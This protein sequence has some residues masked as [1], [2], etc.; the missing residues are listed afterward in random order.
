MRLNIFEVAAR[1]WLDYSISPSHGFGYAYCHFVGGVL[2]TNRKDP[3]A[4]TVRL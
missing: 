2:M 4:A 1:E 3:G